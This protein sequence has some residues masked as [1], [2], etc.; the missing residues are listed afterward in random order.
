MALERRAQM[1]LGCMVKRSSYQHPDA[2]PT[3]L[4]STG[5]IL[6]Q[7]DFHHAEVTD[8]LSQMKT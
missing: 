5:K 4:L 6:Q 8:S 2:T 7:Q 1:Q 3:Q